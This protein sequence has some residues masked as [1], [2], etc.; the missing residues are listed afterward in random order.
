MAAKGLICNGVRR[1]IGNEIST[2]IWGH[3]CIQDDQDPMIQTEMP[4]QLAGAKVMGLIDQNT[5]SWD[6]HLLTDIFQ[7]CDVSRIMKIPISL[8]YDDVWYWHG[9][10]KGCYSVKNDY[11]LIVGNYENNN[12][13]V[14]SK[15]LALWKLKISPKWKTFLWRTI[16][17]IL[18]IPTTNNLLIKRVE[19]DP[20]CAMCGINNE[21]TMHSLV[22]TDGIIYAA[23]ILYHI[24]RE[25]NGAIWDACLPLSKKLL[26]TAGAT[27]RVWRQVHHTTADRAS[28]DGNAGAAPAQPTILAA[29]LPSGAAHSAQPMHP[30]PSLPPSVPH[31]TATRSRRCYV[32]AGY[33]HSSNS[34]TVGAVLMDADGGYISAYNAPLPNCFSPLMAE[35]FACKETLSWLRAHGE[36]SIEL[37]TDCQTLQSYLSSTGAPPRSYIG[38]AIDGC[39]ACISTFNSC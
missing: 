7:P 6:H 8:E 11:R 14:F 21:D 16:S 13:G 24:W 35:A 22:C 33:H 5:G 36:Q 39:R 18:H 31:A 15:W 20:M 29:P 9:D 3:P 17:D 10:P 34:A 19:V 25:R 12:D 1:R 23:A 32:D 38:Y 37:Y 26:A 27:M 4:P 2:L 28:S 30:A